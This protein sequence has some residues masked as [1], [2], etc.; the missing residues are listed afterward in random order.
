MVKKATVASLFEISAS[1]RKRVIQEFESIKGGPYW[2]LSSERL[3]PFRLSKHA[4]EELKKFTGEVSLKNRS[5]L[6]RASILLA[7]KE[8]SSVSQELA[9]MLTDLCPVFL[10]FIHH[11]FGF[12]LAS[13]SGCRWSEF[14]R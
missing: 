2:D 9:S 3:V 4:K 10:A 5:E 12:A 11:P 7:A 14:Q 1:R 6:A 13:W 8:H